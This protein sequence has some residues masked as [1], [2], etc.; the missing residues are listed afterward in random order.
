[1]ALFTQLLN[2]NKS[3][4]DETSYA[5]AVGGIPS[6]DGDPNGYAVINITPSSKFDTE[7]IETPTVIGV[8]QNELSFS[9]DANWEPIGGVGGIIP[10]IGLLSKIG[11]FGGSIDNTIGEV[12]KL[13][14]AAGFADIGASFASRKT[15]KSSGYIDISPEIMIV[16]WDDEGQPVKSAL[17]LCLFCLPKNVLNEEFLKKVGQ[18]V[19]EN[20]NSVINYIES[21]FGLNNITEGV[22]KLENTLKKGFAEASSD[23]SLRDKINALKE[24][25]ANIDNQNITEDISDLISLQK[26]PV[27]VEVRIGNYYHQRDMII[28]RIDFEFSKEVTVNGPLFVKAKLKMSSRKLAR[29]LEGIGLKDNKYNSRVSLVSNVSNITGVN[30]PLT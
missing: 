29:N 17:L 12:N 26:A 1:M 2:P 28:E 16:D 30:L 14:R 6:Q 4:F 19:G 23:L 3:L 8:I 10:N 18:N 9:V 20:V 5:K 22:K 13:G 27:P 11:D 7:D 25:V 15:Y 24:L 21:K